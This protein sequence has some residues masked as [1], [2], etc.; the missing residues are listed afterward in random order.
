MMKMI[1]TTVILG[2]IQAIGAQ[3]SNYG[4]ERNI[5][6]PEV[7]HIN[8][9]IYSVEYQ[10]GKKRLDEFVKRNNFML[11]NQN[12]TKDAYHYEFVIDQK[13]VAIIDS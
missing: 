12:E 5:N 8:Y 2:V 4:A 7:N 6:Y 9:T 13:Y 1:F 3:K 11:V 10:E